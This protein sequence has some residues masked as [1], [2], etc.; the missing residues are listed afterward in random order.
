MPRNVSAVMQSVVWGES[1]ERLFENE[2]KQ[3]C[4]EITLFPLD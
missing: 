2:I 4:G 1:E 3:G